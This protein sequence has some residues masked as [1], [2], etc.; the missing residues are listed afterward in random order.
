MLDFSGNSWVKGWKLQ[1]GGGI[2]F[3]KGLLRIPVSFKHFK[4]YITPKPWKGMGDGFEQFCSGEHFLFT[5]YMWED[6]ASTW[7][8]YMHYARKAHAKKS[9]GWWFS[10][11]WAA[12]KGVVNTSLRYVTG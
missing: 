8:E 6:V 7:G 10:Y 11:P 12:I 2:R 3:A 9:F 4:T 5:E 1:T